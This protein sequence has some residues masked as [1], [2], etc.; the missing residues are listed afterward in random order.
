MTV[1]GAGIQAAAPRS[2]V[3]AE[4][5]ACTRVSTRSRYLADDAGGGCDMLSKRSCSASSSRHRPSTE[6]YGPET[7]E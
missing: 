2:G 4:R 5:K 7:L 1:R 3:G 6:H